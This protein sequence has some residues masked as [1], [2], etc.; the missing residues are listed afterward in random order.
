[1][2]SCPALLL[3]DLAFN[4]SQ[5]IGVKPGGDQPRPQRGGVPCPA[6]VNGL[7]QVEVGVGV[8]GVQL[9]PAQLVAGRDAERG[10]GG[11]PAL[12]EVV[13]AARGDLVGA[14]VGPDRECRGVGE[15]EATGAG[16]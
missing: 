4:C 14:G 1:M 9:L 11:V 6:A 2:T 8:Q 16:S 5:R 12:R 10:V 3:S 7:D 15:Q 13:W